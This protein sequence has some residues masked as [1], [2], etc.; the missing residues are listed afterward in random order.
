MKII[1]QNLVKQ[2]VTFDGIYSKTKESRLDKQ[3]GCYSQ[4]YKDFE[5]ENNDRI[6]NHVMVSIKV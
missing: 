6:K 3:F 4:I 5:I 2:N 1:I